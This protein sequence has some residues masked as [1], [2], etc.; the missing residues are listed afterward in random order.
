MGVEDKDYYVWRQVVVGVMLVPSIPMANTD[1][2]ENEEEEEEGTGMA[3]SANLKCSIV[4][5]VGRDDNRVG[6]VVRNYDMFV[7]I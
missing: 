1:A 2:E 6:D 3:I 7:G 4:E 5:A